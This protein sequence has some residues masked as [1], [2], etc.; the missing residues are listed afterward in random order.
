MENK[1]LKMLELAN[2]EID[3]KIGKDRHFSAADRKDRL[4][5][6]LGLL[7]VIGTALIASKAFRDMFLTISAIKDYENL[8]ISFI[9]LLVGVSTAVLGF[10]GLEKQI[11]QHRVVGNKYIEVAR[12]SRRLLNKMIEDIDGKEFEDEFSKLLAEYLNVNREGESCPTSDKDS[13]RSIKLNAA[14]RAKIKAQI[15]KS[16]DAALGIEHTEKTEKYLLSKLLADSLK[17]KMAWLLNKT[18]LLSDELYNKYTKQ[19]T[20]DRSLG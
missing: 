16:D 14:G 11:S 8:T 3:S 2:L 15:K 6:L 5:T 20:E 12:K 4:K 17:L 13:Q 1:Q 18:F 10:F 19:F 9:S 7:S